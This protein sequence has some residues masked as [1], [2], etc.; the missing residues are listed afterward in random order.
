MFKSVFKNDEIEFLCSKEDFGVIPV[1]YPSGKHIPDWF[2]ALPPKTGNKGFQT[3]T[4]KRCMP[5]LDSM[6]LGY[7]I[8]LAADVQFVV[9][10][11][12]SGLTYESKFYKP[13]VENHNKEQISSEKSP[14]P[15][16]PKP[17]MKF[18][19]YWM[20]KTPP[21]YSLIFLP[22]LN[23]HDP[24]FTCMSGTVDYPYYGEEYVNFPFT[25]NQPNFSG[26]IEA[27]TPLVQV[28]PIKKDNLLTSHRSREFNDKEIAA[29]GKVRT[30]R[31]SVHESLY[32]DNLHKKIK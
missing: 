26:L 4:I 1:P 19:N 31:N 5:F 32:R 12:C 27:G 25:F 11:D 20:I 2:K 14:N 18:L 21:E 3:G 30:I 13:I 7:I 8:P 15:L 24:R 17:P 22:P 28:I 10:D 6:L 9:N 16:D 23:R 29:T